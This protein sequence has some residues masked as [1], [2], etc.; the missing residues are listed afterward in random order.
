[1]RF[2]DSNSVKMF[3]ATEVSFFQLSSFFTASNQARHFLFKVSTIFVHCS[4]TIEYPFSRKNFAHFILTTEPMFYSERANPPRSS[5]LSRIWLDSP[6][7]WQG[8]MW[9]FYLRCQQ[10]IQQHHFTTWVIIFVCE[11]IFLPARYLLGR[12]SESET[13]DC[14]VVRRSCSNTELDR[15]GLFSA[16]L[17]LSSLV[18]LVA[19]SSLEVESVKTFFARLFIQEGIRMSYFATTFV[20]HH[21]TRHRNVI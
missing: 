21:L 13:A 19:D 10:Y 12:F 16:T 14:S 5:W 11:W 8:C 17:P 7:W 15:S 18:R 9:A 6:P 4:R 20:E 3:E 2:L 1:M